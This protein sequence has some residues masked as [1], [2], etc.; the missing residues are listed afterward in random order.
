MNKDLI[1]FISS[2][3]SNVKAIQNDFYQYWNDQINRAFF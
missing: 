2:L 3:E 1:S